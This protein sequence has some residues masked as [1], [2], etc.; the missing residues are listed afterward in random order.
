MFIFIILTIITS[1]AIIWRLQKKPIYCLMITGKDDTRYKFARGSVQNF[2]NQTYS[3]KYL[4]I[5][6]HNKNKLTSGIHKNIF[7][8]YINKQNFTLGDLRNFSLM[9]VPFNAYFCIWDDDDLRSNDYLQKLWNHIRWNCA[10][11]IF[12]KNRYD[13]NIKNNF[14]WKSTFYNGM[15]PLLCRKNDK[16][17][18]ISRDTLEDQNLQRDLRKYKWKYVVYDNDPS[19]YIRTIHGNNT[20]PYID[21]SRNDIEIYSE[22]SNYQE[23]R[24][25]QEIKKKQ[26]NLYL[27]YYN[28]E[29]LTEI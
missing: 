8:F 10:D 18:Y 14:F 22:D 6:N 2:L 15:P 7:E 27:I 29:Q 12:L 16:L 13:Y 17:R 3:S 9:L 28:N 5:I 11:A 26:I 1:C 23:S 21:N 20:S 4:I 19:M 25:T 24:V